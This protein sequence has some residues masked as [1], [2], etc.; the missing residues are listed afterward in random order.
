MEKRHDFDGYSNNLINFNYICE[1]Y[2]QAEKEVVKEK[3]TKQE[4]TDLIVK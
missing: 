2:E 3:S 1:I 4:K